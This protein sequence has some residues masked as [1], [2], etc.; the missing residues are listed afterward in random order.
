MDVVAVNCPQCD[1]PASSEAASAN[2]C[3]HC[4]AALDGMPT[5]DISMIARFDELGVPINQRPPDVVAAGL[6]AAVGGAATRALDARAFEPPSATPARAVD[7]PLGVERS[8]RAIRIEREFQQSRA[9]TKAAAATRPIAPRSSARG[10]VLVALVVVA[11]SIGILLI[12][13]R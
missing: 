12:A 10:I 5:I 3:M 11:L 8:T 6:A 2:V 9:G 7:V 1:T 13:A 4:G